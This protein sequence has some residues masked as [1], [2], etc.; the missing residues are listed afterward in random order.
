MANAY[1]TT[2]LLL[3]HWWSVAAPDFPPFNGDPEV[4]YGLV[5][6]PE[7]IRVLAAGEPYELTRRP[8]SDDG[9]LRR[10]PGL[11]HREVA[12][13]A[14]VSIEY[15]TRLERG[16]LAGVSDVVEAVSRALHLDDAE[17][18]HLLDVARA[19]GPARRRATRRPQQVRLK[20]QATLDAFTGGPAFVRNGRF[21]VLGTNLLGRAVYRARPAAGSDRRRPA[22]TARSPQP[23]QLSRS[24]W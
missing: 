23:E 9:G 3:H 19:Q 5:T 16:N 21:D 4:L 7:R 20:V 2:P 8:V 11:R 14:G 10:V 1:P 18:A 15:Y 12:V 17:L 6:N 22:H 13:L 24:T